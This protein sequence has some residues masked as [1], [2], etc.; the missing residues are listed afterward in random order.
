[1]N[2]ASSPMQP[3]EVAAL[4]SNKEIK[5]SIRGFWDPTASYSRSRS[6]VNWDTLISSNCGTQEPLSVDDEIMDV[7]SH[8]EEIYHI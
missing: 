6:P 2:S 1:M 3:Q 8:P 7:D 4:R 5:R